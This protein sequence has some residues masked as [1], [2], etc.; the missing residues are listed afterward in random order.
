MTAAAGIRRAIVG[1]ARGA[2]RLKTALLYVA[3]G[4]MC[5]EELRQSIAESWDDFNDA[6]AD[7]DSGLMAWEHAFADRFIAAQDRV[8]LVGSGSGRDIVALTARGCEVVGVEPAARAADRARILVRERQLNAMIV[9]GYIEDVEIPGTFDAI[10][11]SYFC[12]ACIPESKR[13][14]A[15]LEKARAH[16]APGGRIIVSVVF[17]EYP[18]GGRVITLGR[19]AGALAR[20]DW[21]IEPGDSIARDGMTRTALAYEHLFGPGEIEREAEAAGLAEAGRGR[22]RHYE[23]WVVLV[24]APSTS[25]RATPS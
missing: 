13:R 11:F 18:P 2:E 25:A 17:R 5:L 22:D 21:R 7:I 24:P 1:A 9:D 16:L 15:V 3:A 12:Y 10:V 8:L 6:D 20:S 14:V 23:P 19:I 4:T